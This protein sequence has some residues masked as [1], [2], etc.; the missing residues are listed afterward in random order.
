MKRASSIVIITSVGHWLVHSITLIFPAI[1][2]VLMDK[3]DVT[4]ISLGKL[5]T[6][7]FLCFGLTAFPAGYLVDR[8]GSR[9]VLSIYFFG[10]FASVVIII[11]GHSIT[12]LAI[13]LGLLGLFSGLYHPAGLNLISNTSNI[14]RNMGYHGISGS[15]GLTLGPLIGG[16]IAGMTDWRIAY[17]SLGLVSLAG[18]LLSILKLN[19]EN[20]SDHQFSFELRK[21][22]NPVHLAVFI[23]GALWGF[24]H[25]GIF[26]FMPI[27]FS[28]SI[29]GNLDA[30]TRGGLLTAL[31]LLLGIFGQLIGGKLGEHFQRK[32]LLVWVVG[33][34]IP[35]MIIMGFS[36]GWIMLASAG[37]L[38]AVNFSYQPV[39]NSLIADITPK[40]NRGIIYG[41][42][43]GLGFGIGSFAATAGGYIGEYFQINFIFPSLT[44][45]LLPAVLLSVWI[46]IQSPETVS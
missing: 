25:H 27:Y 3:F 14:S 19:Y 21:I 2:I 30:V 44:F 42:S 45:V 32:K 41:I 34:N 43:S 6:I 10:I 17:L 5:G 37:I 18:G 22:I 39:T 35:F 24:A 33:L 11:L 4:L 29:Q 31:V 12:E 9:N 28:E 40:S 13:G 20:L 38:G 23:V 8:F 26:N 15:L 1:M 7:Q 16:G 46:S 36:D